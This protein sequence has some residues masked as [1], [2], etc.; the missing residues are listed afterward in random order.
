MH[1]K[2]EHEPGLQRAIIAHDGEEYVA[3]REVGNGEPYQLT[4][5]DSRPPK[6]VRT[7]LSE[8]NPVDPEE[9]GGEGPK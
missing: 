3:E 8:L 4:N 1:V 6:P 5:P 2:Y 7:L 9:G